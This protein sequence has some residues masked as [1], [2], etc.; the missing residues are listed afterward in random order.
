MR[1][2]VVLREHYLVLR[3]NYLVRTRNYLVRTRKLSRSNEKLSRLNDKMISL[4][5]EIISLERENYLVLRRKNLVWTREYLVRTRK[6]S[7]ERDFSGSSEIISGQNEIILV[8]PVGHPVGLDLLAVLIL[9]PEGVIDWTP[10]SSIKH[11]PSLLVRSSSPFFQGR[12]TLL[13]VIFLPSSSV[14]LMVC[15]LDWLP[16]TEFPQVLQCLWSRKP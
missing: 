8:H 16:R 10:Y 3:E 9:L 15:D 2:Y 14:C 5:R 13:K 4:K 6:I 1:N 11:Q 7:F 12:M